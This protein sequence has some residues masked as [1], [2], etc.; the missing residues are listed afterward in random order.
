MS[1]VNGQKMTALH[2]AARKCHAEVLLMFLEKSSR[3]NTQLVNTQDEDGRTPLFVCSASRGHGATE[4][5][6]ELIRFGAK[7][8]VQDKSQGN[9]ALHNAAIGT[10]TIWG[11][12]ILKHYFWRY[13][14]NACPCPR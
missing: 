3:S 4:C 9:T 14:Y 13:T 1:Q 11:W 2:L 10:Y 7:L 6:R 5:M 12:G 8:D